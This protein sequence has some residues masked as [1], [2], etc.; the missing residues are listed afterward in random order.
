[1]CISKKELEEKVQEFS[2]TEEQQN[3]LMIP[4]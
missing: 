1:M 3:G 4:S 2:M